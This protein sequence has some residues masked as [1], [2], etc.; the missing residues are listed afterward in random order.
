MN[1]LI[2]STQFA[3]LYGMSINDIFSLNKLYKGLK[4]SEKDWYA[5]ISK[6]F[7]INKELVLQ[8]EV[9][10]KEETTKEGNLP[11]DDDDEVINKI[12]SK[13]KKSN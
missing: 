11:E 2:S 7:I 6:N 3:E 1:E 13:S 10:K 5:E 9:I 8:E 4:L 12:V